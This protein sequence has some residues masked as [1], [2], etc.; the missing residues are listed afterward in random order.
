M[1]VH[2]THHGRLQHLHNCVMDVLVGPQLRLVDDPE[3]DGND[4]LI[5]VLCCIDSVPVVNCCPNCG[6]KLEV[7]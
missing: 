3:V 2:P 6:I 7:K 1:L 4:G 5:R